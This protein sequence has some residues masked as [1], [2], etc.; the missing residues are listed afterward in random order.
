M[1]W[2][3]QEKRLAIYIRD[4]FICQHCQLDLKV[5]VKE[6]SGLRIELDHLVPHSH[7]GGNE[8]T[9]LVTSCNKCNLDR[10]DKSLYVFHSPEYAASLVAQAQLPLNI[11][12]AK[13]ILADRKEQ[14]AE[15]KE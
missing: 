1:N 9:N 5:H 13:Q 10:S 2:L 4:N 12:L 11:P 7:G 15:V 14:K 8:A 6:G 3:R